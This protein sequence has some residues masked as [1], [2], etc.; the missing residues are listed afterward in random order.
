MASDQAQLEQV[1]DAVIDPELGLPLGDLGMVRQVRIRRHRAVVSLALPVAA[2][3]RLEELRAGLSAA[4]SA[5]RGVDELVVETD[6]MDDHERRTLR[7]HLRS[8]H[9]GA[10]GGRARTPGA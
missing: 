9:G 2:W 7:E 8:T 4:G 5:V 6:A 3:P 1:L 10:G